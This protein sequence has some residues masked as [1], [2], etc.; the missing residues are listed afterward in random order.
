MV[1]L[2]SHWTRNLVVTLRTEPINT[3]PFQ[4]TPI[5]MANIVREI[6]ITEDIDNG[7]TIY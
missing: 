1:K 6:S 2:L 7:K 4:L 3:I 5:F